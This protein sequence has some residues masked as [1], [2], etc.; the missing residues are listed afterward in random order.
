[1]YVVPLGKSV[2]RFN[3]TNG[4]AGGVTMIFVLLVFCASFS[5]TDYP[6]LDVITS[7]YLYN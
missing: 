6:M 7:L 5:P 1:M 4:G 2:S 3:V